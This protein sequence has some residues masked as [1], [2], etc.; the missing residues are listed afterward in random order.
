[1]CKVSDGPR[2]KVSRFGS[3]FSSRP[4]LKEVKPPWFDCKRHI[5]DQSKGPTAPTWCFKRR[6]RRF[7][8]LSWH[9]WD[10]MDAKASWLTT[11][12]H[13]RWGLWNPGGAMSNSKFK[14]PC[15]ENI[16][17][18]RQSFWIVKNFPNRAKS[19][20]SFRHFESMIRIFT[21]GTSLPT[22]H[23]C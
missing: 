5:F 3:K 23:L 21:L 13:R 12:I 16:L 11:W 19:K 7:A 22:R 15:S 20:I 10:V 9:I 17:F 4:N 14:R 6:R 2:V 18:L 8:F 1:M